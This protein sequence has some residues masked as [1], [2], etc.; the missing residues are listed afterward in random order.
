MNKQPI[1][2]ASEPSASLS[3]PPGFTP[4]TSEIRKENAY[5][6]GDM[7]RE[8]VKEFS[9][10]VNA[11]VMNHSQEFVEESNRVL[12]CHNVVLNGGPVLGVLEDMI[13]VGKAMGYSMEGCVNDLENI[14]GT[15]G[16]VEVPDECSFPKYSRSWTQ[17]E[18][19]VD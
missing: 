10:S 17:D 19:G 14:I 12:D 5:V 7:D 2:V 4:E 13:R 9:P 16:A 8:V 1:G 15:H 6:E 18:K 3:H 11:K